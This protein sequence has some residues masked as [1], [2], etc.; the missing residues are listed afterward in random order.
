YNGAGSATI[1]GGDGND[2]LFGG[3]GNDV[4]NGGAGDDELNGRG[5]VDTLHGG[6]GNDLIFWQLTGAAL[7]DVDGGGG[8]DTLQVTA[9]ANADS[10]KIAKSGSGFQVSNAAGAGSLTGVNIDTVLLLA[11]TGADSIEV[12]PL[13]G[14]QIQ[15]LKI[16]TGLGDNAGDLVKIV[17]EDSSADS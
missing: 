16:D 12:D 4:L 15:N 3:S 9:T 6:D 8:T 13:N 7:P 2:K 14:S 10:L 1:N 17:G 5:G 11:G